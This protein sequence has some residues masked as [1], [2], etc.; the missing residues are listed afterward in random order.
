MAVTA[1]PTPARKP[2]TPSTPGFTLT[3]TATYARNIESGAPLVFLAGERVLTL[4]EPLG[5]VCDILAHRTKP[6][7]PATLAKKLSWSQPRATQ[8]LQALRAAGVVQQG[9]SAPA[10][11]IQAPRVEFR[12]PCMLK[13]TVFD[14]EPVCRSLAS[15]AN[16]L[17]SRLGVVL[18][19]VGAVAQV[20]ACL[21]ASHTHGLTLIPGGGWTVVAMA[22]GLLA[23]INL[24]HE[25]AHG[26]VLMSAGGRPRRLGVMLFYLAPAFFCDVSDSFRLGRRAQTEVAL[27]GVAVQCQLGLVLAPLALTMHDAFGVAVQH[28]MAL[29]LLAVLINLLPFVALDGYFVLRVRVGLPNLREAAM[30]AWKKALHR[31]P[32]SPRPCGRAAQRLPRWAIPYGVAASIAPV[33][34]VVWSLYVCAARCWS[35]EP[36]GW[37]PLGIGVLVGLHYLWGQRHA[38]GA[39]LRLHFRREDPSRAA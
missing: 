15:V 27:A 10:A 36:A 26:A 33:V 30:A 9:T 3:P 17:R 29:N 22:L 14:P 20:L 13:V 1:V 21:W 7:R 39:Y 4:S 16:R 31:R 12:R 38:A 32:S 23:L 11:P 25:L 8:A 37:V 35:G 34:L 18:A 24:V 6:V 28:A 5:Q 2:S 19:I